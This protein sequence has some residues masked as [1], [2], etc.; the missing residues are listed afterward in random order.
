MALQAQGSHRGPRPCG[1][2]LAD[3]LIDKKGRRFYS[4][5]SFG[6]KFWRSGRGC[7]L[8]VAVGLRTAG[9]AAR[10]ARRFG[11]GCDRGRKHLERDSLLG[12]IL[13]L[14]L[15]PGLVR[16]TRPAGL[17]VAQAIVAVVA[18]PIL[19]WTVIA[20][21]LLARPLLTRLAL[22]IIALFALALVAVVALAL[23]ALGT[24]AI[25]GFAALVA[26]GAI[27]VA[28]VAVRAGLHRL[29]LIFILVGEVVA[30]A[31]LL[32]E[33]RAAFVQDAEIMIRE[34]KVI[35]GLDTITG[36]LGV[37]RQRL[38]FLVKLGCVAALAIVLAVA[39]ARHVV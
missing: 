21:T 4:P 38:V 2:H 33:A 9:T 36:E 29:V 3:R 1:R 14:L 13:V 26:P 12:T 23:A 15:L 11:V 37:A 35:F 10:G 22:P 20:G 6:T 32:F 25:V 28:I 39:W 17:V 18:R 30:L 7:D 19:A 34:L 5:P 16:G 24:L 8:G 27:V 31:A